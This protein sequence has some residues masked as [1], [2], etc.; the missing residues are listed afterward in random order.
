MVAHRSELPGDVDRVI[1]R[2][3]AKNPEDRW[4]T[5]GELLDALAAVFE[6]RGRPGPGDARRTEDAAM[7]TAEGMAPAEP[8]AAPVAPAL[9]GVSHIDYRGER[10]GLGRTQDR[11]A[12]WDCHTGGPPLATFPLEAPAWQEAW[13]T[14]RELEASPARDRKTTAEARAEV[15]ERHR[16]PSGPGGP[17]LV[18]VV[19]LDYRGNTFALGRT[20]E[21]YA[22]WDLLQG[23]PP[24]RQ[25]PLSAEAWQEAWATY[26][27]WE[28]GESRSAREARRSGA[29]AA[30]ERRDLMGVVAL[31]Y[32][33]AGY[34]LGRT[35]TGYAVWDLKAGGQPVLTFPMTAAA[36]EQA[37][38]AYQQLEQRLGIR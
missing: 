30:G 21:G 7:A 10:Y 28:A 24:L 2:A 15:D 33:G 34:G 13:Q 16:R 37:W 19:F 4:A 31:D 1:A 8:E 12:V 11:F 29:A 17:L 9:E 35:T 6:D 5:C 20:S 26:Q 32:R 27:A 3:M 14:Y 25:Y 22:I 38:Q 23:G 36:W 18:G